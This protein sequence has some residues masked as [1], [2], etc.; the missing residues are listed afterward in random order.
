[1]KEFDTTTIIMHFWKYLSFFRQICWSQ[2]YT[3]Q[4]KAICL[5][6]V[7]SLP[8]NWIT[9][10]FKMFQM[11][12]K[13]IQLYHMDLLTQLSTTQNSNNSAEALKYM[14]R[15]A[16]SS[17]NV[18]LRFEQKCLELMIGHLLKL[19]SQSQLS[20]AVWRMKE[21]QMTYKVPDCIS[22]FSQ[23]SKHFIYICKSEAKEKRHNCCN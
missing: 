1:M 12:L 19:A 21:S 4:K 23:R 14:K 3:V 9:S 6:L 2:T 16:F 13:M 17:M 5:C 15:V 18:D 10:T 11:H 20:Q 22:I 7:E 8:Q